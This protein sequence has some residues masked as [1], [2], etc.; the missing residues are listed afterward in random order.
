MLTPEALVMETFFRVVNKD[1]ET[2]D[3]R[4]NS[5]QRQLDANLTGRDI[6]PKARQEG[7]STY[8][9]GRYTAAC[10]SQENVRAVI[11]S[12]E[13]TSTQ[14][15]LKRARYFV[16]KFRGPE[17]PKTSTMSQ[18]EISFTNT[19]SMIYIGTA[20]AKAFG[21]GDTITHLHCSEYAYWPNA[22][23]LLDGLVDA[24]PLNSGEIAIEST[25]NG[26]GN[27][28]Y[29]RCM[30]AFEGQ[31]SFKC[32]F[33]PWHT[34]DEYRSEL[35]K[36]QE[37][38]ILA[39]LSEEFEEPQLIAAG[40]TP[41]QL[42]WRRLKLEEKNFDLI[43]F[44]QEYPMTI[45]ECFQSSGHGIFTKYD[46]IKG[47]PLW[48]LHGNFL[49]LLDGHPK[50]GYHYSLGADPSGGSGQDN[51]V[52][53][54]ICLET[55]EQVG[56]YAYNRIQPD[57]FG[58]KIANTARM[59]NDAFVVVES[60]NHGPVTLDHLRQHY[61]LGK[62]Y[63]SP[64]GSG[65][66]DKSLMTL[67]FRTTARSRPIVIGALNTA[68]VQGMKIYSPTLKGELDTFIESETGKLEAAPGK[69]DD[70]VI[71]L[72][73]GNRGLSSASWMAGDGTPP[74]YEANLKD[75]FSIDHVIDEL[76]SKPS[77]YPIPHQHRA[78]VKF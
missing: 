41:G 63:M 19:N 23:D 18:N 14:R 2:V 32:H 12:H 65:Y 11:I 33:F 57:V 26:Q 62:I 75:P 56:E 61:D 45:D 55:F 69:K 70:R 66:E 28:Y 42:A 9:L 40:I 21:R 5:A 24:V 59:F 72:A 13:T 46:Y 53:E 22:K 8:F 20:G 51:S 43:K 38:Y 76:T 4:L 48:K 37:E 3:F 74:S 34:F 52:M 49:W 6:I 31:S 78:G 30:R 27:D 58:V 68:L 10:L 25:G 17:K 1:R 50:K 44:K 15:L 39:N 67:G 77:T 73:M 16:D 7:I 64:A 36:E 47:S 35:S 60:N 71:A 29:D 54:I